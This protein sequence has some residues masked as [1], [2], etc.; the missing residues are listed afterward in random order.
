MLLELHGVRKSFGAV[1]ALDG[2]DFAIDQGEV[3]GLVGDNGAG[4][5]TLVK[6][7]A[8]AHKPDAGRIE[9]DGQEVQL[10]S[11]SD[12][13]A[14]GIHTVY[15]DLALCDN[16][17]VVANLFLGH[18][19]AKGF[20]P[21]ALQVVSED[22]M[23]RLAIDTLAD[24]RV[25]TLRSPR[26]LVGSLSGGQRQAIAIARAVVRAARVIV[27]DEP[28]AAL[29]V[30]QVTQVRRL[31]GE[32]RD[33]QSAVLLISHNLED[34]FATADRICVLRLGRNAGEFVVESTTKDEVVRAITS[35]VATP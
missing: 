16:L 32:L 19:P 17:D 6:I 4:K 5:S 24:L 27:L 23:E 33:R 18:E 34:V 31:I 21:A 35:G 15:Q 30:A 11:P 2:V 1:D 9:F 22:A 3:V 10:S 28:T 7:I 14:L 8:G 12:S 29:G 25:T 20:A 13:T 26:L